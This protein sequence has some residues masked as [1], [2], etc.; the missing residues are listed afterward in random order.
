MAPSHQPYDRLAALPRGL[1]LPALINSAGPVA[2][3][4]E[5]L[6]AWRA[7]LLRG[8]LPAAHLDLG[9]PD[10]T[11][12]MRAAIGSLGLAPLC[13]E[14]PAMADQVLRTLLWHLDRLIDR[15]TWQDRPAAIA[16]AT[17]AFTAEWA[18]EKGDWDEVLALLQG[19]GDLAS[20]RW[21]TLRGRLQ[22]REWQEARRLGQLLGH[23]QALVELIRQLG[24]SER[25]PRAPQAMAHPTPRPAGAPTTLVPRITR[26]DD[27]PGEVQ[28]IRRSGDLARMLASEAAQV[29]H[30]VL[31]RLWRARFAEQRLLTYED[32][33]DLVEW[34]PDPHPAAQ[35][36]P[37][38]PS[39]RERG[40]FIVCVDTSGSMRGAPENIAKAIVLQAL[41]TAHAERRRCLLVAFG[42]DQEIAE[43]ELALT[44]EGLDALLAFIGQG[45]DGG[46]DLQAPLARVIERVHEAGWHDADLLIA[47]DGE[48]GVTPASLERL[49]AARAELGLRVQGVLI[50]DRETMGL[51]EVCDAIHWVRDWRRHTTDARDA[52]ADGFTPVH[53]RSLTALF[54]PNALSERARRHRGGG[55][56]Q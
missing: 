5:H 36:A 19:L 39:P 8:E 44:P 2:R 18:R 56:A 32:H 49:D 45:F 51:L 1:W 38:E 46:T 54:F 23:L 10:S 47:S 55:P 16:P 20:L 17:A 40:P 33:A 9:D 11:A 14:S 7:A 13:R 52:H 37:P 48:F 42:G 31:R 34:V 24:R 26:L 12:P 29:R 53:S 4:L 35:A 28:G 50:G 43:H 41:R 22:S 21:D 3:R 27:A 15:P 25:T 30:P 6:P